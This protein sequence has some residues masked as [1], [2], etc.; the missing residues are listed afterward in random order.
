MMLSRIA[1]SL[2]WIGRYVARADGTARILDVHLQLLLEDPWVDE[3]TACESLFR[4]MGASVEPDM[5][6]HRQTVLDVLAVDRRQPVSIAYSLSAAREN[7]RRAREIIS[8]ELWEALNATNM[9]MPRRIPQVR[10]HQH[11]SWLRERTALIY[12]I[13]DA[14]TSRDEAWYFFR[15]GL[16]IERADMTARLLATRSLS[17]ASGPSWTTILR[18]C[19]AY[20]AYLRTYRGIPSASKAAEFLI[21]DRLFPRSILFAISTAED[22]LRQLEPRSDR[23]GV[24]DSALRTLGTIRSR[25]EFMPVPEILEDITGHMT[26]VQAAASNASEAIRQRYFPTDPIPTWA[27]EVV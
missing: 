16:S 2:F 27:G 23:V 20:E 17:L 8:T 19:G 5:E 3:A 13:F 11:F 12:G 25:L 26:Q 6:P 21:M 9:R 15:L 4:V 10:A 24:S 14:S 1:E 18:S 7:A 22:C